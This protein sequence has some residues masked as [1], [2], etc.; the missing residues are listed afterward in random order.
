MLGAQTKSKRVKEKRVQL[1]T[2]KRKQNDGIWPNG[3]AKIELERKCSYRSSLI[4]PE[5]EH[6]NRR[7]RTELI[8]RCGRVGVGIIFRG[9]DRKG[10]E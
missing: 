6:T 8:R 4:E 9:W 5:F 2:K 7:A 3:Y 10:G 1:N